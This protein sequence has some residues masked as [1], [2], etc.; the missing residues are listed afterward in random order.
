MTDSSIGTADKEPR[1]LSWSSFLSTYLPALI[2]ALGT[3]IALPAIPTLARSFHVSFSLATG[4]T[5]SFLIGNVAGTIPSGWLVDRYGRRK[6]MLFGPLLTSA[7]ALLVATAHSFPQLIVYR[8]FDGCAAQMWLVGR[9]AGISHGASPGQ[10]GK[11]VSWMFGMNNTGALFGPTIGGFIAADLGVRAPFFAY[12][13]LALIALIPAFMFTPD[14]PRRERAAD[15]NAPVRTLSIR[16]IVRPRL[17]FFAV[18]L[19]AGLARGPVSADLLHLYAA[20]AYHLGPEKIGYL[21]TAAAAI[22]LPIGFIAGWMM[23]RFGRKR[24]MIPGFAGV[25]ITMSGLA[26]VAFMHLSFFWYVVIFLMGIVLQSLTGGSIQTIGADVAP[27][28]ARGKFLGI[29]RFAGQG[30]VSLSP[31]IF[32]TL[33]ATMGYG[34]AFV[35]I[36]A[37]AAVVA[38]L[39]ILVVPETGQ[40]GGRS[41]A[42]SGEKEIVGPDAN[43]K[44]ATQVGEDDGDG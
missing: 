25:V 43:A 9:L 4:I 14:T 41:G 7:V 34:A 8:F 22:S 11:Q 1:A 10:R 32:A 18:A 29:Y 28:E 27:P 31:I 36:A 37:A 19:F 12:A 33:T 6:V 40:A 30:G 35:F 21:A 17:A 23:D 39:L 24:T 16:E 13:I 3:G 2:L 42:R 44:L 5:T 15:S 38:G 26:V 20:Y